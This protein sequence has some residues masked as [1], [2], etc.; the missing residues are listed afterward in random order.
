MD[1]VY[2]IVG[3]IVFLA[4]AIKLFLIKEGDAV[5]DVRAD[6]HT[7]FKIDEI[8]KDSVTLSTKVEFANTGTQC[9]TIMDC[10]VRTLLPYEQFDGVKAEAKAEW[11]KAPREDDYFEAVLIQKK[12]NI[13]VFVK[14]KLTARKTDD[15][16]QALVHMVDLPLDLVYQHTGR[17]PWKISKKRIVLS[18]DEIAGLVGIT[19]AKD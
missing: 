7:P 10:Y 18:A 19:L 13:H 6:Q 17:H 1:F 2:F 3:I 4:I 14:V 5:I 9:G 15:I 12:G 16:K 11:E 8:T